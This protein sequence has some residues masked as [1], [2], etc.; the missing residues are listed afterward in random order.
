MSK[1]LNIKKRL[2]AESLD[3]T[4]KKLM[5]LGKHELIE[6]A[7]WF[8]AKDLPPGLVQLKP[9]FTKKQIVDSFL[10]GY[11]ITYLVTEYFI[12]LI[13]AIRGRRGFSVLSIGKLVD[14]IVVRMS[15]GYRYPRG[16][17]SKKWML[18]L[19]YGDPT[20]QR[21]KPS[22]DYDYDSYGSDYDEL[23]AEDHSKLDPRF[24]YSSIFPYR[25]KKP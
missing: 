24:D 6:I 19:H 12:D 10:S 9:K 22:D 4:R 18:L 5:S 25:L 21:Y 1:L 17:R 13:D 8:Q 20:V 3:V 7:S 2:A 14:E 11:Q 16:H 15:V 23:P